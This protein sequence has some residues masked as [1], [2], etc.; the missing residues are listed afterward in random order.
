MHVKHHTKELLAKDTQT[1]AQASTERPWL[2][3]LKDLKKLKSHRLRFSMVLSCSALVV[4]CASN[5]YSRAPSD[6]EVRDVVIGQPSQRESEQPSAIE[7]DDPNL[8][9]TPLEQQQTARQASRAEYYRQQAEQESNEAS[10]VEASLSSAEYY[11]QAQQPA[12]AVELVNS[13]RSSLMS[14]QQQDRATVILAYAD[15]AEGGYDRTLARLDRIFSAIDTS[16]PSINNSQEK[17]LELE[18][19]ELPTAQ[20]LSTQQVD[21]YLLASF[22]YQAIGQYEPAIDSLIKRESGLYGA[23]RAETTR[24]IWQVINSIPIGQREQ[25]LQQTQNPMVRNRIEQS[26]SDNIGLTEQ[27]PQQF[28]QWRE[29]SSDLQPSTII[30]SDWSAYSP[31]SIYVLLPFTSRFGKAA[32]AVKDGIERE[33]AANESVYRPRINYYDIGDNPLQVAQYYA[34]AVRA[35]A[36]FI[37]GPLGKAHSNEANYASDYVNSSVPMLMLGGDQALASRN[38]RLSMSPELEGRLVAERAWRDG[39]ISAAQIFTNSQQHQRAQQ[40]FERHWLSLGGKISKSIQYSPNQFDHSTELKQLFDINQSE[41][42]HRRLTQVLGFKPKFSA[43]QRGDIDFVFML[44]NNKTGRILRPQVNFFTNSQLPVYSTSTLYNGIQ[45]PVNDMDLDGTILPVMPWVIRSNSV[46]QYAGQLNMLHAMGM[47]AYRV[48]GALNRLTQQSSS[49]LN[50]N[51]GQLRLQSNGEIIY[52][53]AW[54]KFESG[55]LKVLDS[56]GLD[57]TPLDNGE[58]GEILEDGTTGSRNSIF[59]NRSQNSNS[60]GSYNDQNWDTGESRRKVGG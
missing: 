37:I 6:I 46:A 24:Y 31:K 15:Y 40:G 60:R 56:R 29:E 49:A 34:A 23:S 32:Q 1:S 51:T 55:E 9:A 42:R 20:P 12:R 27:T 58:E 59:R 25:L 43:Y 57:I 5:D 54:A 13:V 22:C 21:A 35:G 48:A 10:R 7:Y 26:L 14:A 4:G 39:H 53:P 30:D 45:D 36:D 16:Q 8:S 28:N 52:Q 2:K 41:Y 11:I 33:H 38:L 44:A 17:D 3:K 18:N 47:D 50:G 19:Q